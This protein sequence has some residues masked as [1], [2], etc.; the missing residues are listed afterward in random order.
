VFCQSLL[1]S[2]LRFL[3]IRAKLGS[4]GFQG[5]QVE[6][7]NCIVCFVLFVYLRKRPFLMMTDIASWRSITAHSSGSV[8]R[9]R[10]TERPG[11]KEYVDFMSC[12]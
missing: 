3:R 9:W 10:P 12:C 6:Q 1:F 11:S 2:M 7:V 5:K 4:C 8:N